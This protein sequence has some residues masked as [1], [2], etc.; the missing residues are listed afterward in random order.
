MNKNITRARI[1]IIEPI[2]TLINMNPI[3]IRQKTSPKI[4]EDLEAVLFENSLLIKIPPLSMNR[5]H[6]FGL[7][8][9]TSLMDDNKIKRQIVV[10]FCYIF[11]NIKNESPLWVLVSQGMKIKVT[12]NY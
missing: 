6:F 12:I 4:P 7:N 2:R 3:P 5:M 11:C 10:I 8:D 1:T 9:T